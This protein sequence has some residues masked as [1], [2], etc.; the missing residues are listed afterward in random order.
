[1][2]LLVLLIAVVSPIPLM[3]RA[4]VRTEVPIVMGTNPAAERMMHGGSKVF[5]KSAALS[6]RQRSDLYEV[7]IPYR[8]VSV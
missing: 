3:T 7:Y 1:M 8:Y 2:N 4:A 5:I 6:S